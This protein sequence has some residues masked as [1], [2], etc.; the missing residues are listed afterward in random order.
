MTLAETNRIRDLPHAEA[1]S[2]MLLD[3]VMRLFRLP[4]GKPTPSN[5]AE[6]PERLEFEF[7]QICTR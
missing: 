3:K 6:S 1:R 2:Q 7:L 5:R 4:I